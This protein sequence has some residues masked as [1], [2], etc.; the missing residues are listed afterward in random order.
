MRRFAVPAAVL[1]LAAAAF[2]PLASGAAPPP[3]PPSWAQAQIDS[4]VGAG[5]MGTASDP[6]AF[7]PDDALTQTDLDGLIGGLTQAPVPARYSVPPVTMASLDLQLVNALGLGPAAQQFAQSARAAGL[8]VPTRFGSEVV[9]RLLGLRINHPA[10]Q[11]ALELL[12][13]NPAT[14]AEAAYSAARILSFTGDET[15]WAED[16]ATSFVLP[17]YTPWQRRIVTTALSFVG[18]PYV[19]GG[20]SEK[21][22]T[23]GSVTARGGF[24]CSG[25]VWR[26]Y[27]LQAYPN[28]GTLAATLKGR[29]T[30]QMSG[31]VPPAQ[32]IGI[33]DVQPGDVLFF[34]A[35]GPKSKPA[36]VDHAAIYLGGGWFVHSSE[37]GVALAPLAGWYL[38]KF[39]WAR[40]PLAEA[41]LNT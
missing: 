29:T 17:A 6:A 1:I 20:T 35:K 22:E 8:K 34:G 12:P 10:K 27:K 5:L 15:Q 9:A 38:D 19:W 26:V 36:Q 32:R 40:R 3:A 21:Q 30:M 25:F 37:Y 24:D 23:F 11:D 13:G 16:A 14:R 39:A 4:V 2:A 18:F 33:D 41:G 28:E 7:R 31:E